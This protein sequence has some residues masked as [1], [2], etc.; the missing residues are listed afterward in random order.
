MKSSGVEMHHAGDID[1]LPIL[2]PRHSHLHDQVSDRPNNL[3]S[4]EAFCF[5]L[6]LAFFASSI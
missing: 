6:C 1:P 2:W 4:Q 5:V 3:E